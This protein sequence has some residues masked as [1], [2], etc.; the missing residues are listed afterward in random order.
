VN[1]PALLAECHRLGGSDL[2]LRPG[3]KPRGRLHGEL[4]ELEDAAAFP[5]EALE[6]ELLKLLSADQRRRLTAART[7]DLCHQDGGQVPWRCHLFREQRGLSAAFRRLAAA[8]PTLSELNLPAEL[9]RF[10][11]LNRGLVIFAGAA[12]AG[13]STTLASLLQSIN[14][15]Y[16]RTVVTI[17]DPVEYVHASDEAHILQRTV[18]EDTQ[19]FEQGLRDALYERPDVLVVGETRSY[20]VARLLLRAAETGV[21]VFTTIHGIDSVQT[22]ERLLDLFPVEE[23]PLA[24]EILAESLQ[25][26]V[27]QVLL[28]RADGKGRVPACE[29]LVRTP[30]VANLIRTGR[31][32]DLRNCVQTGRREGMRLLDDSLAAAVRQG[33]ANRADAVAYAR[34]PA[35][36]PSSAGGGD[37]SARPVLA[38]RRH[39]P[40]LHTLNLVN[41]TEYD[42]VGFKADL[43]S[44]RT[45][46]L[47]H[48]GIR[49]ELNHPLLLGATVDLA[50]AL[51][52]RVLEVR[53]TVRDLQTLGR[54]LVAVGL[55]FEGLSA[56]AKAAIDEH[57]EQRS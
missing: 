4:T 32:H 48:D 29:V 19:S 22:V 34:D 47:S 36:I 21:L 28:R 25:G 43:T 57:L 55:K 24:R 41:V 42:E 15:S 23:Q 6:A 13:K 51:G 56:E 14:R 12:G 11:H 26:V 31:I 53:A 30:A 10:A 7:L 1:V 3:L 44:G 39:E 9:D 27:S 2:H 18:G 17:E 49:L 45:L 40:R 52:P 16:R 33:K 50:L 54:N 37:S 8:P 38:E 5:A 20:E 46:D 35:Q